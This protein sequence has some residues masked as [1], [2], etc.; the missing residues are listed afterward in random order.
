M[1]IDVQTANSTI[2]DLETRK[3]MLLQ[4]I[5]DILEEKRKVDK[6]NMELCDRNAGRN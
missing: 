5:Y 1:G 4:R 6:L 2:K 3:K